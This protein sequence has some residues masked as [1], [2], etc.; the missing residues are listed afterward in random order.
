MPMHTIGLLE[1]RVVHN[2]TGADVHPS[3]FGPGGSDFLDDWNE[4]LK[5][6]TAE[7]GVT[8][9]ERFFTV[10]KQISKP[11]RR[12]VK[13]ELDY[14][15]FGSARRVRDSLNGQHVGNIR[16]GEVP[17]DALRLLLRAPVNGKFAFIAHE[18]IGRSSA[19][20][21]VVPELKRQFIDAHS[22]YHLEIEYVEDSDAWND[23]LDGAA[24]KQ[25]TFVARRPADG[26]RAGRPTKELYDILPGRRGDV[27]PRGWLDQ[28]RSTGH[29]PANQ[30]LSVP[31]DDDEID[32]TRVV[33]DKGGRRRTISIGDDW[34]RFTW[35][36]DPGSTT[37]PSDRK[38]FS[39]AREIVDMQLTRL[40]IDG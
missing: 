5:Q 32:E 36:I 30:V 39:A 8:S 12:E 4:F 29:L 35:E 13:C 27:L 40:S 24:L 17:S 10:E 28:L 38:F 26:N 2:R 19:V 3:N 25:L 18:I 7:N 31:V 20:G 22:G 34:P 37:R 9:R 21:V 11:S 16:T 33:V 6:V 14:G 15:H 23:F 1:V